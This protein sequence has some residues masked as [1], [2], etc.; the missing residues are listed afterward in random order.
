[1][2]LVQTMSKPIKTVTVSEKLFLAYRDSHLK[3]MALE[4][5]GVDNWEGYSEALGE[6]F[7]DEEDGNEPE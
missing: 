1:M 2:F 7:D 4:A 3:L 6:L 5:A